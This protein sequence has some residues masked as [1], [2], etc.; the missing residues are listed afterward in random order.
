MD[1]TAI[2]LGMDNKLP[3]IVFNLR[4]TGT[5]LKVVQGDHVGTLVHKTN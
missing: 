4:E 2:T 1:T 5:M 3:I